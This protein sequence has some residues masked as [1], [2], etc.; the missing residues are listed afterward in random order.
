MKE[1]SA[2]H[3]SLVPGFLTVALV[4][5]DVGRTSEVNLLVKN[6]SRN[7]ISEHIQYAARCIRRNGVSG[8][9]DWRA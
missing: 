6:L 3:R 8:E 9:W 4:D 2:I 7:P 1:I 5:F